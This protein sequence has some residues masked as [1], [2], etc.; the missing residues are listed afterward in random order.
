MSLKSGYSREQI[1]EGINNIHLLNLN[2]NI[3]NSMNK[4]SSNT[5]S[6]YVSGNDIAKFYAERGVISEYPNI[7]DLVDP[8]FVDVLSKENMT[9]PRY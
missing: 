3:Q 6:L 7:N 5:T 1:V 2:Y 9:I 4:S 8:Q